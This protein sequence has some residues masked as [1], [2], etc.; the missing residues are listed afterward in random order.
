MEARKRWWEAERIQL[1]ATTT[2]GTA[3]RR[4]AGLIS[5]TQLGVVVTALTS[6]LELKYISWVRF[7]ALLKLEFGRGG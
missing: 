5:E 7:L 3:S 4:G 2:S 1:A 6:S